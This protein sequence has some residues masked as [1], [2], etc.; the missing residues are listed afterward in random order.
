MFDRVLRVASSAL[1]VLT[2]CGGS[3]ESGSDPDAAP[4]PDA[5]SAP[6]AFPGPIDPEEPDAGAPDA[7]PPDTRARKVLLIAIDG[8][9]YDKL[10]IAEIPVMRALAARGIMTRTWIFAQP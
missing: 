5:A 6:D 7:T 1:L 2:A 9:R 10:A 4:P 8:V 3:G